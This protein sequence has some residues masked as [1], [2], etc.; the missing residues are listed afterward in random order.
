MSPVRAAGLA[1]LLWLGGA[2]SAVATDAPEIDP[3]GSYAGI[4]VDLRLGGR[5]QG[6]FQSL[7]GRIE[8]ADGEV[9]KVWV[10]LDARRLVLDGPGWMDRS[11]RSPKFLDVEAHPWIRFESAPFPPALVRE[12]GVMAGELELR[13]QRRPVRFTVAPSPCE[14][15]GVGCEITVTGQVSRRDFGMD[16]YR[17]WLRDEV[18]FD[19]HVRL[20]SP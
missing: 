19:F 9:L 3:A 5:V 6:R 15:P 14:E 2:L 1:G 8:R 4:E 17:V 10:R 20:R 13:G 11:M 18:G 16:A 7:E 12:G